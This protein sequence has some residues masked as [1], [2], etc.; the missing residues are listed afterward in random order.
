MGALEHNLF[1]CPFEPTLGFALLACTWV[2][3][4]CSSFPPLPGALFDGAC[5]GFIIIIV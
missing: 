3:S 1:L 5:Q 2:L 4:L